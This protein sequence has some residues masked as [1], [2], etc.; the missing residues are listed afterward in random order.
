M[1]NADEDY[2]DDFELDD[3]SSTDTIAPGAPSPASPSGKTGSPRRSPL[4]EVQ[5]CHIAA[6]SSLS[7]KSDREEDDEFWYG[8]EFEDWDA[9][10]AADAAK[11]GGEDSSEEDYSDDDFEE[12]EEADELN[13]KYEAQQHDLKQTQHRM[14][15]MEQEL[16][17]KILR[18]EV[19]LQEQAR[20]EAEEQAKLQAE[21]QA[22]QQVEERA[23]KQQAEEQT[24]KKA[25]E[26]AAKLQ[27]EEAR[28]K[29]L[30]V[31]NG[32]LKQQLIAERRRAQIAERAHTD[33]RRELRESASFGEAVQAATA[34]HALLAERE[35]GAELRERVRYLEE[36]LREAGWAKRPGA[37]NENRV[38]VAQSPVRP[39]TLSHEQQSA[40][41]SAAR[42]RTP[43]QLG[44]AHAA[45]TPTNELSVGERSALVTD[46][47]RIAAGISSP[48]SSLPSPPR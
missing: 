27:A 1:A 33:L 39:L 2:E 8:D 9:A 22:K 11:A 40:D 14:E 28:S 3:E 10:D 7:P 19:M 6:A 4:R 43:T 30:A 29:S 34:D 17:Q 41:A 21:E 26:Q 42:L 37:L 12:E 20:K 24:T 31:E 13:A 48:I 23:A 38:G 36:R 25:E 46:L 35:Q 44:S 15:Q 45:A 18:L 5:L 47:V 16:K 32:Q